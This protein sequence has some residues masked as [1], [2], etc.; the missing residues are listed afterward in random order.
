MDARARHAL[1]TIRRCIAADHVRVLP[2]FAHRM[3]ARGIVWADV[4]TIIDDP[5]TV[6]GDGDDDW[7]RPRW[8][9]SG[10]TVRGGVLGLVCVLGKDKAGI[11]TVFVT[12]FWEDKP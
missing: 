5:R 12:A 10:G 1:S 11:V 6:T 7:G 8:I 3:D 2:H 4:R 9:L